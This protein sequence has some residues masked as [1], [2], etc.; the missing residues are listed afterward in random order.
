MPTGI[1]PAISEWSTSLLPTEVRF[2]L[3]VWLL[4]S[5]RTTHFKHIKHVWEKIEGMCPPPLVIPQIA[6]QCLAGSNILLRLQ[7]TFSSNIYYSFMPWWYLF[8]H[9]FMSS[10]SKLLAGEK[11]TKSIL[12]QWDAPRGTFGCFIHVAVCAV[13][14]LQLKCDYH[15]KHRHILLQWFQSWHEYSGTRAVHMPPILIMWSLIL[16][17]STASHQTFGLMLHAITTKDGANAEG[18]YI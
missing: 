6:L 11:H 5:L 12:C 16:G 10:K 17:G 7:A 8:C 4:S 15:I 9:S 2:I 3:V 14:D 1:A 18:V 13:L